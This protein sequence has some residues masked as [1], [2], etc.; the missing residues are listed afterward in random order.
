MNIKRYVIVA[1]LFLYCCGNLVGS[2]MRIFK[3]NK[4]WRDKAVDMMEQNHGSK[5]HWRCL[6]DAEFDQQIRIK[7]L[8]AKLL[9]GDNPR[10]NA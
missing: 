10:C 4:L 3:Q 2:S 9:H 5:I 1:L 6:D 7:L 8:G